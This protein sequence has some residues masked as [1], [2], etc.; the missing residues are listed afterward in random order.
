MGRFKKN[1]EVFRGGDGTPKETTILIQ[2]LICMTQ[3]FEGGCSF[4]DGSISE[5][6]RVMFTNFSL[7][8]FIIFFLVFVMKQL[9]DMTKNLFKMGGSNSRLRRG[10]EGYAIEL[11]CLIHFSWYLIV[12][13]GTFLCFFIINQRKNPLACNYVELK[14]GPHPPKPLVLSTAMEDV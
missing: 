4:E 1:G 9:S 14:S 8:N 3:C 7:F 10:R 11:I 13:S 5:V 2:F 6:P 12:E